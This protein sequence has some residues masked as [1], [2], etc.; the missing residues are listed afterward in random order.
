MRASQVD[1]DKV[2]TA[3]A[4]VL[5]KGLELVV[6]ARTWLAAEEAKYAAVYPVKDTD[7]EEAR[8]VARNYRASLN[9]QDYIQVKRALADFVKQIQEGNRPGGDTKIYQGLS[10]LEVLM[11]GRGADKDVV[12]QYTISNS[13]RQFDDKDILYLQNCTSHYNN[14]YIYQADK[15]PFINNK[16]VAVNNAR[17]AAYTTAKKAPIDAATRNQFRT[18]YAC[19]EAVAVVALTM[20]I[21][22]PPSMAA[23][24]PLLAVAIPLFVITHLFMTLPVIGHELA[25][26]DDYTRGL[27][28]PD[29]TLQDEQKLPVVAWG[30]INAVLNSEPVPAVAVS[31]TGMF[32]AREGADL[33]VAA[34]N[35][36]VVAVPVYDASGGVEQQATIF[37]V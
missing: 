17:F 32:K 16:A 18:L 22:F 3:K 26:S 12:R 24:F 7:S 35:D 1:F 27:A 11:L 28:A 33:I 14:Y 20:A 4:A 13:Y 2:N 6:E 5:M 15:D 8:I 19:I 23:G 21:L 10:D 37:A 25:G 29:F 31:A 34:A 30:T 9:N 36:T